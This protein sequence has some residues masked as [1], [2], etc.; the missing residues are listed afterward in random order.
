M[1][2]RSFQTDGA[3]LANAFELDAWLEA[4][5]EDVRGSQG[6]K[7]MVYGLTMLRLHG[8]V[9]ATLLFDDVAEE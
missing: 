9:I 8:L 4:C 3:K 5:I 1:Y 6:G 7:F 2:H